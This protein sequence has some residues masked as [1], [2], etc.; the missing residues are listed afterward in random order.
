MIICLYH[1]Y[2]PFVPSNIKL[3]H[4]ETFS[5]SKYFYNR[6]TEDQLK[7]KGSTKKIVSLQTLPVN[8]SIKKRCVLYVNKIIESNCFCSGIFSYVFW[9]RQFYI[10]F[11]WFMYSVFHARV[12]SDRFLKFVIFYGT[13]WKRNIIYEIRHDNNNM[14][15]S[16]ELYFDVIYFSI[17]TLIVIVDSL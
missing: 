9:I 2:V 5:K 3:K 6:L 12:T 16:F 7:R 15:I 13:T 14:T 8:N 1:C 11:I 4:T 10:I 17:A